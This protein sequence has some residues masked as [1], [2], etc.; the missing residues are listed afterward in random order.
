MFSPN[1]PETPQQEKDKQSD[2]ISYQLNP[3]NSHNGAQPSGPKGD[4]P[5]TAGPGPTKVHPPHRKTGWAESTHLPQKTQTR[6]QG[7]QPKISHAI[8]NRSDVRRASS[9]R[10]T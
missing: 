5:S 3:Q 7:R 1:Q 10:Y 4:N 2:K 8:H 6:L 9:F